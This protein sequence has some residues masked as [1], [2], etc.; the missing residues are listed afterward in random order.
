M[1]DSEAPIIITGGA[2]RLGLA[3]AQAL[4]QSGHR[5]VITYRQHR[6]ELDD[7]AR[8]GIE[9]L[10]ADFGATQGAQ[11]LADDIANRYSSLRAIIHNA[12]EWIAEGGEQDDQSTM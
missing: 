1:A 11:R 4:Q 10:H 6:P 12:S 9:I 8:S 5:V 2:Q 7:I 3:T